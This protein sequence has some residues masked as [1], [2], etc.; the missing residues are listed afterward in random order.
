MSQPYVLEKEAIRSR[1]ER[2]VKQLYHALNI[3]ASDV[4]D[5]PDSPVSVDKLRET[6]RYN[7]NILKL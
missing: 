1:Y 3:H 7:F 4:K 5:L 6:V 2:R